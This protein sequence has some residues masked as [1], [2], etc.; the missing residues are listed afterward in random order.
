TGKAV[1]EN[2]LENR[3]GFHT[4][5][6]A[7]TGFVTRNM[8]CAPIKSLTGHGITGAIQVL[9][10]NGTAFEPGDRDMLAEIAGQLSVSIESILLYR[11]ILRISSRLN[12]EVER[13][14]K[15]YFSD[16]AFIAE[17]PGMREVLNQVNLLGS[18]PVNVYVQ[19]ENGTGKELIARMVHEQT[20]QD[21]P[22]VAVNCASIPENLME[23]EF[24]GYEKGAF[25][26]ANQSRKGYFEEA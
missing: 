13:F 20:D 4:K 6:D 7:K 24:F 18:T 21:R 25:T 16:K 3:T 15:G 26:G 1:I 17:S 5:I 23:S 8:V 22:F 19:G 12:R 14:H 11:E 9:N 2:N 10:K